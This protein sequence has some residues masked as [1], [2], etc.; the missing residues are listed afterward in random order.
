MYICMCIWRSFVLN[1]MGNIRSEYLC[2]KSRITKFAIMWK[3]SSSN[4]SSE[5][6]L[7]RFM[8][9]QQAC[10]VCEKFFKAKGEF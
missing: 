8:R 2:F 5:I 3:K 7:Q 1:H 4:C 9:K 6:S 10:C